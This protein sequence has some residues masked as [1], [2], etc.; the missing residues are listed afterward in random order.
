MANREKLKALRPK[1]EAK[2]WMITLWLFCKYQ[3][4]SY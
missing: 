3:A 4:G 2:L 1:P